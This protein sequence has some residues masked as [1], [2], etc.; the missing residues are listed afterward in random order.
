M[1]PR[2][3]VHYELRERI[4]QGGMGLVYRAV[5]TRVGRTVAIKVLPAAS[6]A[7]PERRSRFLREARAEAAVNHPGIAAFYDLG[8][9]EVDDP[10][11]LG[12]SGGRRPGQRRVVYLVMEY[13]PG[14]DLLAT[15]ARGTLSWREALEI[16]AQIADALAA[17]HAAGVVHRDLKPGN[18][19][20][21]PEGR[22]KLLD[23]GLA[24]ILKSGGGPEPRHQ[25]LQTSPGMILGT[26]PY[27]APEQV[28]GG[29]VDAR[30]DLF[31]LGVVVYQMIA[32]RVP[33]GGGNFLEALRSITDGEP[34]PLSRAVAGVPR[35][36]ERIVERLLAKQPA[37]RYAAASEVARDLRSAARSGRRDP[38]E[39]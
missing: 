5:D 1:A 6:G 16:G 26:A 18:I 30:T 2:R 20:I 27:M 21:T 31:T 9:A 3:L 10:E 14:E 12:A 8:E 34:E 19:R 15:L 35:E 17:A 22:V 23:F 24:K 7:E 28:R 4:G 38:L 32:G 36:V 25:T 37:A 13:V 39:P 33:F 11:L 29:A